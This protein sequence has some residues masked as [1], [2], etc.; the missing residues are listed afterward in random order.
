MTRICRRCGQNKDLE[1][2]YE[3]PDCEDGRERTCKKCRIKKAQRYYFNNLDARK[4]YF[5]Q[6]HQK[7]KDKVRRWSKMKRLREPLKEKAHVTVNNAL[8]DGRLTKQL[9]EVCSSVLSE[10]HHSDYSKPLE[11]RWLCRKH[12]RELHKKELLR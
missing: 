11:I 10:A 5:W 1:D 6:Y 7:N 3:H 12:H 9:C 2:F 8:R 4:S